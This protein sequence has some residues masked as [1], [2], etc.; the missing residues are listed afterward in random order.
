VLITAVAVLWAKKKPWW[1][2]G[3][4]WYLVILLPV[5]GLVQIGEQARADR[6]TYIALVGIFLICIKEAEHVLAWWRERSTANPAIA[7]RFVLAATV[8]I[9]AAAGVTSWHLTH[10]WHDSVSVFTRAVAVTENNY[11]AHANLAAA[12]FERGV[13]DEAR[14]HYRTALRIHA[15]V[16]AHFRRAAAEAEGRSDYT[17]AIDYYG[18]IVT[19]LT[20]DR[21][22]HFRLG[23][24][25]AKT[26]QY[27]K[28]LGQ[29]NE[30]LHYDRNAVDAR[31]EIAK[32]L[33]AQN[34]RP[35]ARAMLGVVLRL[36]PSNAEA[37]R[38]ST[39]L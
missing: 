30:V 7:N 6:Y 22:A 26:G 10:Y 1:L 35:E 12:L 24:L 34:R 2:M 16:L 28:A 8:T 13:K 14:Q 19:L 27:G 4:A 29:Y 5:L 18:R 15:P 3:W 23:S 11:L 20:T 38:L 32:V 25:L 39:S 17:T 33:T 21:E 37:Q 36:D 31:L 9:L